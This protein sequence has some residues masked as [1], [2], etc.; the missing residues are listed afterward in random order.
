[1]LQSN[2]FTFS[3]QSE[4]NAKR[5]KPADRQSDHELGSSKLI[6]ARTSNI[7]FP[8]LAAKICMPPCK[9]SPAKGERGK[10]L[11]LP[12]IGKKVVRPFHYKVCKYSFYFLN[13][14]PLV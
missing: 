5:R 2:K 6:S 4:K 1:M 14:P 7:C 13:S 9:A 8:I 11:K 10:T 12:D 3:A